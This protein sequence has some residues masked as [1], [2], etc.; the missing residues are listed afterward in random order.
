MSDNFYC[1]SYC[2]HPHRLTDGKPINHECYVLPVKAL[3]MEY[4]GNVPL[5]IEYLM[6][7]KPL[8]V[9]HGVKGG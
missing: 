4:L 8:K 1:T 3:R 6:T 7:A 9:H 5:A 2:N